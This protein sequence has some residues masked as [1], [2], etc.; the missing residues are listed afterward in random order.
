MEQSESDER[1]EPTEGVEENEVGIA[2][3]LFNLLILFVGD[4][5]RRSIRKS[6]KWRAFTH[7]GGYG[8]F[9]FVILLHYKIVNNLEEKEKEIAMLKA[10]EQVLNQQLQNSI[11]ESNQVRIEWIQ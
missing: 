6:F 9:M 8:C 1:N 11:E 10:N 4:T 5:Y 3:S 2:F 7:N